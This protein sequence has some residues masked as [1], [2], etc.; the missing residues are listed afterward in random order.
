MSANDLPAFLRQ[1]VELFPAKRAATDLARQYLARLPQQTVAEGDV[2][3]HECV[4]H[5]SG[6][7]AE[8]DDHGPLGHVRRGAI[9]NLKGGG[10]GVVCVTSEPFGPWAH[11]IYSTPPASS[12]LLSAVTA[13]ATKYLAE[14]RD[15][16]ELCAS[17]EHYRDVLALFAAIAAEKRGAA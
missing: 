10:A 14:E 6:V 2:E 17:S 1:Q 15:H 11:P 7:L 16:P 12:Q 3:L 8:I 9:D 4:A 13:F 5:L